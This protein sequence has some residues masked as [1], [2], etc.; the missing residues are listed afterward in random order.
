MNQ[1]N[2][3]SD[4]MNAEQS[5][6]LLEEQNDQQIDH[7]SLQINQLRQVGR[8]WTPTR[9]NTNDKCFIS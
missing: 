6:N 1:H 8:F 2:F 4:Q 5:H 9:R 7:L 3:Q